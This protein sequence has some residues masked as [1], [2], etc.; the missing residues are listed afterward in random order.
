MQ[1]TQ[2]PR[3]FMTVSSV[4]FSPDG[5]TLYSAGRDAKVRAYDADSKIGGAS[6]LYEIEH[7]APLD[8]LSINNTGL[9]ATASHQATDESI[10]VYNRE[11]RLLALSP[12]R[13]DTQTERAIYPSALR[14]GASARH[15]NLL[16]A[17]FSIDSIDEE[18]DIAGETC[19]WDVRAE[20]RI[21]LSAVTRN[22]FDVAWNP[23][24]SST[25]TVFAVASTPGTNKVNKGMRSIVQCFA[26]KQNRAQRVLEWECPAFDIN[27]VVYCPHDDNLIAVGAT[28]GKVYIWDQRFAN[29][30][31]TPLH[32]LCHGDSLNVLD[33]DREPEVADTGIRF[34]SWGATSSRLYTGS[35]DGV[36][37]VWNPY[38][39]TQ[40]AH[41]ED[42]ATFTSAIMSGA[43]SA[44]Y[45]DLLIGEDQGRLNLLSL[46]HEHKSTRSVQPYGLLSA[47]APARDDVDRFAAAHELVSAGQ[48]ELRPMGAFPIRQAV[49]G[50]HYRG[51]YLTPSAAAIREAEDDLQ[52]ALDE[53][54]I[55]HLKAPIS[56]SQSDELY[57]ALHKANTHVREAQEKVLQLQ[58]RID[59]AT[60]LEPLA[61]Q[62]QAALHRAKKSRIKLEASLSHQVELCKLWKASQVRT[63]PA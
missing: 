27:D 4:Q 33:H 26:P 51:P 15:S 24:P 47:T 18:R 9:L 39:S 55:A 2:D 60:L 19:L 41:I 30:S 12:S 7:A 17:G 49:Q 56:A 46:G 43:F 57:S 59:D 20:R 5:R 11:Q 38:R 29:R 3:L 50:R 28:D 45:R 44:D 25:S 32:T 16:L 40:N 36:V 21:E 58:S 10:G 52:Q 22:V 34:L 37:K 61:Q 53:Q 48:I 62:N 54:N 13:R 14:W 8:L 23:S 1:E 6:C 35:S 31:N 63:M 42:I